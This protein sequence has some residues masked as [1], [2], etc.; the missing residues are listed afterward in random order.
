[1]RIRSTDN[2][3]LNVSVYE[4]Y[5]LY[6]CLFPQASPQSFPPTGRER[7]CTWICTKWR[8]ANKIFRRIFLTC[9]RPLNCI[10]A[11]I[12]LLLQLDLSLTSSALEKVGWKVS[13]KGTVL[14]D[15]FYYPQFLAIKTLD[16]DLIRIRIWIPFHLK[17]WIRICIR[18]GSQ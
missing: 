13:F 2:Q 7:L 4:Y 12:T 17:C 5:A 6:D 10:V 18:N 11:C 15:P 1:M 14:C 3:T 9:L 16:P 8:Y